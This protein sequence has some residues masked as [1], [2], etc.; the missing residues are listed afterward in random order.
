[1]ILDS[2]TEIWNIFLF[3]LFPL[4]MPRQS[5]RWIVGGGSGDRQAQGV[6][7]NKSKRM[8]NTEGD[9]NKGG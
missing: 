6:D 4:Q 2:R 5:G 3:F 9:S 1:M 7:E 8:R